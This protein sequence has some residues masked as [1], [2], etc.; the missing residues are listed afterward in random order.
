MKWLKRDLRTVVVAVVAAAVTAG[1][2]ALAH[3]VQH[4]LFAHNADKVDGIH[5]VGAGAT[6]SQA[7]GKLVATGGN[8][9]LAPKFMPNGFAGPRAFATVDVFPLEFLAGRERRGFTAVARPQT[10]VY[11]ITVAAA[12]GIDTD[13]A[14]AIAVVED[15][16]SD[17]A[18]MLAFWSTNDS[19]CP[20]G[21][22][23]VRTY[24]V[25]GDG[26]ATLAN[27]VAF[28]VAVL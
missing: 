13:S 23:A 18:N 19:L 1:A 28:T 15:N 14:T 2:P 16:Q 20:A 25:D 12:T 5:A 17:G 21:R 9:R 6:P 11:C 3:G 4:A 7:A 10:G 27:T 8:G 22:V 24:A 26:V